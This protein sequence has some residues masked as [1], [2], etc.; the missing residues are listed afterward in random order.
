MK[1]DLPGEL[2]AW[3]DCERAEPRPNAMLGAI[4][5]AESPPTLEDDDDEIVQNAGAT[6]RLDLQEAV[7]WNDILLIVPIVRASKTAPALLQH[8]IV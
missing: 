4:S 3:P 6:V 1:R 8:A 7:F 5:C 2:G